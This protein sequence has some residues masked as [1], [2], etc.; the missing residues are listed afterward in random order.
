M[1]TFLFTY[2][3]AKDY[4]LGQPEGNA[5]WTAWFTSM[6]DSVT[7][8]G[9]PVSESAAVGELGDGTKFGGYSI[10]TAEDLESAVALAKGCPALQQG[11]GVE[12]GALADLPDGT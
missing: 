4:V 12:V 5:A 1:A 10:I 6:A 11:G 8:I 9:R 3:T 7:D 2:R